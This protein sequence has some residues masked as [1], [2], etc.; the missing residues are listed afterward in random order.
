MDSHQLVV[1]GWELRLQSIDTKPRSCS[2]IFVMW[3][4]SYL[5]FVIMAMV[6]CG[7]VTPSVGAEPDD[8][9]S[10]TTNTAASYPMRDRTLQLPSDARHTLWIP[11][12]Y[13]H[14]DNTV[15]VLFDF[16][17]YPPRV[18][19]SAHLAGLNC[20]VISVQY[21]GLSSVYRT[22]FSKDRQLF[23]TIL[24]EALSALRAE[25]DFANDAQW[26]QLA[27]TS[28]S[29][30][31]GAVREIL[32]TN[33]YFDRIAG[34]YMVDSLYC[35]Y[36]GDGTDAVREGVVHP[37]LMKDFLRFAQAAADGD[38]VMIITHCMVPTP[39]YASTCETADYLLDQLNLAPTPVDIS[40]RLPP[41]VEGAAE[42]LR[43]YR[44]AVRKGF[45]LYGSH[46]VAANDHVG[47]L[48]HMAYWLPG[49]PLAKREA[50][51]ETP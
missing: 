47:H 21:A 30:G 6:P 32:K 19:A 51:L 7:S 9:L 13:R 28:F 17:G 46:G 33:D 1:Y 31:F 5:A 37:G 26:G 8:V 42:P 24:D 41:E 4:I 11:R 35:G 44:K 43:L 12:D 15:D 34:I 50:D 48:R 25:P 40:V 38:K 10:S 2:A 16:H 45:S 22:P 36:I 18:R 14:H 3:K 27:I 29:A 23:A 49:L 39:G 20:V